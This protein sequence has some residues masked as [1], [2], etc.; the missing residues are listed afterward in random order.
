MIS[1]GSS[2]TLNS[3]RRT[4]RA[5]Q[6]QARE[7]LE[8]TVSKISDTEEVAFDQS[9]C[10]DLNKILGCE[11]ADANGPDALRS[12]VPANLGEGLAAKNEL[13]SQQILDISIPAD[14]STLKETTPEKNHSLVNN[15]I[16]RRART[17]NHDEAAGLKD[18]TKGQSNIQA[19]QELHL[20]PKDSVDQVSPSPD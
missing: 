8:T 20:S 3:Y 19:K 4:R 7:S 1:P 18:P 5:M 13:Q 6:K 9:L 14:D 16:R 11:R 2:A 15:P 17:Y 10:N 12:G